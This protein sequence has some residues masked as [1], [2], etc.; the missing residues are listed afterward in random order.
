[1]QIDKDENIGAAH[2]MPEDQADVKILEDRAK[3]LASIPLQTQESTHL[4][5]YIRFRLGKEY[6]GITYE[7][8]KEVMK[9]FHVTYLP[10]VVDYIDGVINRRGALIAVIDLKKL[11]HLPHSKTDNLYA[12]IITAKNM[13]LALLA[14]D[15]ESSNEFELA[16]LSPPFSAESSIKPEFILGLHK[17]HTAIIN[18]DSI[19]KECYDHLSA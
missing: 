13:T 16:Q 3:F 11:F 19:L 8:A 9:N 17:G 10:H 15:I 7:F 12:I 14:D 4:I 6:Y 1:M 5:H 18:I 2:F